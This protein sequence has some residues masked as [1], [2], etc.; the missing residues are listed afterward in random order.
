MNFIANSEASKPSK[1]ILPERNDD[2]RLN[3]LFEN[4]V[5]KNQFKYFDLFSKGDNFADDILKNLADVNVEE[6]NELIENVLGELISKEILYEP[7][8]CLKEK[9]FKIF[10]ELIFY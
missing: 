10:Y 9:V 2:D 1:P 3:E 6:T 5:N 7:F 8:V 4:L